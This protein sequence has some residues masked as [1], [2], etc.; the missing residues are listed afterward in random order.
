[1]RERLRERGSRIGK[2]DGAHRL[3]PPNEWSDDGDTR[4]SLVRMIPHG[5]AGGGGLGKKV[6]PREFGVLVV[7]RNFLDDLHV[8]F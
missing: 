8:L 4:Y 7:F 3:V 5:V 1:M 6:E 2:V